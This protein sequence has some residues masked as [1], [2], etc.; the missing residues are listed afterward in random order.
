MGNW[1]SSPASTLTLPS[2]GEERQGSLGRRHNTRG[3]PR[4]SHTQRDSSR[5]GTP[6]PGRQVYIHEDALLASS[7][8]LVEVRQSPRLSLQHQ[9]QHHH[10]HH[11]QHPSSGSSTSSPV[12]GSVR[13]SGEG[14]QPTSSRRRVFDVSGEERSPGG[15]AVVVVSTHGV[16]ASPCRAEGEVDSGSELDSEE[17][18]SWAMQELVMVP[19]R[20]QQ[21]AV[22]HNIPQLSLG[23][24]M[25][26]QQERLQ[27]HQQ[28]V[29]SHSSPSPRDSPSTSSSRRRR[30]LAFDDGVEEPKML[31]GGEGSL[32]HHQASVSSILAS[33]GGS[34]RPPSAQQWTTSSRLEHLAQVA[35]RGGHGGWAL[36]R[37]PRQRSQSDL[38]P[39]K[40][41]TMAQERRERALLDSQLH[42]Q[43]WAELEELG[44]NEE[45][46]GVGGEEEDCA[47]GPSRGTLPH[48][49]TVPRFQEQQLPSSSLSDPSKTVLASSARPW[50]GGNSHSGAARPLQL[51]V[52]LRQRNMAD[53]LSP[54]SPGSPTHPLPDP[55]RGPHC[56][57]AWH[58]AMLEG[59]MVAPGSPQQTPRSAT[60]V[61]TDTGSPSNTS[62]K[63]SSCR[64]L[65][66]S[67][68]VGGVIQ[69]EVNRRQQQ[70]QD[71]P[72][73]T[74][75]AA[76]RL[77]MVQEKNPLTTRN[78]YAHTNT[79][80]RMGPSAD[81]NQRSI[82]VAW[83][84]ESTGWLQ[85]QPDCRVFEDP[86]PPVQWPEDAS[87]RQSHG[88]D[89]RLPSSEGDSDQEEDT[90]PS[91]CPLTP[92]KEPLHGNT[93]WTSGSTPTSLFN[94]SPSSPR[95]NSSTPSSPWGEDGS[96]RDCSARISSMTSSRE[97]VVGSSPSPRKGQ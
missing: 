89:H 90:L 4:L 30:T 49:A 39:R 91:P 50:S 73:T 60:N 3:H 95:P 58:Q 82:V 77:V 56:A 41:G 53:N 29:H 71:P 21:P 83:L 70:R 51:E 44:E 15:G 86:V 72:G 9:H 8:I 17:D 28:Q 62:P 1:C 75:Q 25:V 92:S 88:G 7:D 14:G 5:H 47:G 11:H 68:R 66:D 64:Y 65:S 40:R 46:D 16:V 57:S 85:L 6:S 13:N 87:S 84:F 54:R 26:I 33:C 2:P 37:Q 97:S 10:Q 48:F 12:V 79:L 22:V 27:Q 78:L 69:G 93:M 18:G 45:D 35:G 67:P 55:S 74:M 96:P 52:V 61:R 24:A 42:R 38:P 76:P 32:L 80:K 59:G 31:A 23:K 43:Q 34:D 19:G 81:R 94:N 63:L 36:S 20:S